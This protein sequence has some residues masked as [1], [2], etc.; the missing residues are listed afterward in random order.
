MQ[1]T[2]H[3]RSVFA[4][5]QNLLYFFILLDIYT[6]FFSIRVSNPLLWR[7]NELL[8]RWPVLTNVLYSHITAFAIILLV[9]FATKARK[10]VDYK[11]STQ[12]FIPFVMGLLLFVGSLWVIRMRM[13]N[14]NLKAILYGTSYLV[15]AVLLHVAFS[16]VSKKI[17]SSLGKDRWNVEGESFAQNTQLVESPHSFNLPTR[18][19]YQQRVREGWMNINPFRGVMVIGTPGSGKT[20]SV[21]IPFIKQF[22]AKG[23]S[24]LVY[25]FK[26]PDLSLIAYHHYL[27]GR[28]GGALKGHQ[29]HVL[30]LDRLEYSRRVNPLHPRYITTLA[31]ATETAETLIHALLKSEKSSGS[32]QFF[33]QSAINFVAACIYYFATYR[34]GK[35][36]T[37]PHVLAFINQPYENIFNTL[38]DNPE[39][40]ALLAPF[41]SA[42]DNR[43]FDQLEG[44]VGTVRVNISRIATKEAFWVFSAEDFDLKISN[45]ASVL[46]MA[47]S[48]QTQ[49]INSAFY[50]VVVNRVTK[51]VNT[52]GNNPTALVI[53]ETPTIYLHKVE[54][55]IATARS[56]KVAV[57]LGLQE[58]PQFHQQYGKD[59]AHSIT[60][61]MGTI[62][63]GSVRNKE[64]LDWLE[65]L[66]GK[67]KQT[68]TGVS[69]SHEKANVNL[70]ERM[71]SLIPAAKIAGLNA[72][73]LVGLV[74]RESSGA[75]DGSYVPNVFNCKIALDMAAIEGEKKA[76]RELPE[77]YNFGDSEQKAA[78]LLEHMQRIY[79]EVESILL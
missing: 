13:D 31:D 8:Y 26:Y 18:F 37:L 22:L 21:I 56:N 78:F 30:N 20:E 72:G 24:M 35:Y 61:I 6:Q 57:V 64:T 51:L 43:A 27:K 9:S 34:M 70:N 73:E 5:F 77:I 58:L 71:D 29:F 63:S 36:S 19:Y 52:K 65:K 42:F 39:L 44:Q 33:T 67:V 49:N 7:I 28:R 76:Y 3:H 41:R 16:N 53:D 46:V 38:F 23:F 66:F 45:P 74:S 15:G 25:D 79:T 48:P 54:N 10:D 1:E 32:A 50:S 68:A 2:N 4:L 55:L 11:A 17:F 12:F 69:V 47:N 40:H 75:Y 14:P 60:S 59:V 62:L